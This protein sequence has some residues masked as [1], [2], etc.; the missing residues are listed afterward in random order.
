MRGRRIG[1]ADVVAT[2]ALFVA[3]GGGAWALARDS[4]DSTA[5]VD[6]SVRS[7]ELTDDDVRGVDIQASG[8]HGS[9]IANGSLEGTDV[10]D[11]SLAADDIDEATFSHLSLPGAGVLTGQIRNIGGDGDV[12]FGGISGRTTASSDF[13]DIASFLPSQEN[14]FGHL[15]I[16]LPD[17]P[18]AG[19]SRTFTVVLEGPTSGIRF[20]SDISCTVGPNDFGGPDDLCF[21]LGVHETGAVLAGIRIDSSGAGLSA[22][23]TAYIGLGAEEDRVPP[24]PPAAG[25]D[26]Q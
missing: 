7:R 20:D 24:I 17:E 5:I 4:V 3:L 22:T 25:R 21:D 14:S 10:A 6:G 2:V 9:D 1:Y 16:F 23:D 12:L 18:A 11:D 8:V 13:E 26:P 19:E 15:A